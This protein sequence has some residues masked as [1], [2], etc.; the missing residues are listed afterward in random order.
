MSDIF[1]SYASPDRPRAE[2]LKAWFEEAGWSVW[3]D[4]DID[5]GEGWEQRI[6]DE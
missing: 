1:I 4:R 6:H 2:R 3:I 5:L